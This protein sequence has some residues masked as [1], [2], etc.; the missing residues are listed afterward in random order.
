MREAVAHREVIG[1]VPGT[2]IESAGPDSRSERTAGRHPYSWV[3]VREQ[4]L[5]EPADDLAGVHDGDVVCHLG[6]K[7]QVGH[8]SWRS[9]ASRAAR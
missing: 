6:D 2:L 5:W 8:E 3:G 7:R 9:R 4:L 1:T